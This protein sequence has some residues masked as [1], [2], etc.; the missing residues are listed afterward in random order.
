ME[1]DHFE[2]A[3]MKL[4]RALEA[5]SLRASF[6]SNSLEESFIAILRDADNSSDSLES[7]LL[8]GRP[9]HRQ[10][11]YGSCMCWVWQTWGSFIRCIYY[12]KSSLLQ[13]LLIY[14]INIFIILISALFN[15]F[16][17]QY[18][19][20]NVDT[21]GQPPEAKNNPTIL[22]QGYTIMA[23]AFINAPVYEREKKIRKLLN[24]R[25]LRSAPYWFGTFLFDYAAFLINLLL[26]TYFVAP[27][28]VGRLGSWFLAKQGIAIILFAHCCSFLF[29]KV[30]TA[31]T[32]FS[33]L[34][35][36]VGFIIIPMVLFGQKTFFGKL[37]F[38]K[39][40][41]PYFDLN[42]KVLFEMQD[43]GMSQMAEM[44]GGI[45]IPKGSTLEINIILY[46]FLLIAI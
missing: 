44:A 28:E 7:Q 16:F 40:F 25:G 20:E 29:N 2:E 4:V 33:V 42:V 37:E 43:P 39:Y 5:D 21:G 13:S 3:F 12:H 19:Q 31:Q 10:E 1:G 45:K 41:Y 46:V 18:L 9:E 27:E 17:T 26:M 38:I 35:F 8:T 30:K 24:S 32:W 11:P 23:S 6:R 15:R 34:N 22:M 36:L 14:N